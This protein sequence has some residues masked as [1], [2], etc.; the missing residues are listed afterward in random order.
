L[1][2]VRPITVYLR[3]M[4]PVD[5]TANRSREPIFNIP[6][7]VAGLTL[8][9]CVIHAVLVLVLSSRQVET[10]L[11]LFAFSPLRYQAIY[12]LSSLPGGVPA[13]IW[14]FVSYAFLHGNVTHL[15]V[16]AVWLVAFGTPVARRF[17]AARFLAF[18]AFT[19]AGGALAHLLT[20]L[21]DNVPV[22]GASAAGTGMMAA[23]LRFVMQ[24]GGPLHF[25]RYEEEHTYR[26][27]A[28]SLV[29]MVR[30]PRVL[31]IVLIWLVLNFVLAVPLFAMPGA[32]GLAVAW[33]SH[34]GGFLAGL[35]GFAA[36]DPAV[37]A[38]PTE[39]V[40]GEPTD[41]PA[42]RCD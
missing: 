39:T 15:A 37:P 17:G 28:Q 31:L 36:F 41:D 22:I 40:P 4:H 13:A 14:T 30:S 35:L 27:P 9:L 34:I 20:H 25:L 21:D 2:A 23:A 24:P 7:A 5:A 3:A 10:V 11:E 19:A 16:N 33:Q 42:S 8:A 38:L 29:G 26:V 18:F 1:L 6:G 12:D 32:E